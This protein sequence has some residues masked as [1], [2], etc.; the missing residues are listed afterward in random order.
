MDRLRSTTERL[1][2]VLCLRV[3]SVHSSD[4][5]EPDGRES[6]NRHQCSFAPGRGSPPARTTLQE[7]PCP[8]LPRLARR[9]DRVVARSACVQDPRR[10]PSGKTRG[11]MPEQPP[12]PFSFVRRAVRSFSTV[13]LWRETPKCDSIRDAIAAP[14]ISLS[15][16]SCSSANL[17]TST[18]SLEGPFGLAHS[19]TSTGISGSNPLTERHNPADRTRAVNLSDGAV[20]PCAVGGRDVRRHPR[21]S[22]R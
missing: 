3:V 6:P 22:P 21:A 7:D 2:G 5:E 20:N 16:E 1:R 8:G 4:G 17:M 11:D 10:P 14:E 9:S 12:Q 19:K 15:S 13:L 18:D